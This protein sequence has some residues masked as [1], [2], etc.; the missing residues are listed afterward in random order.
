MKHAPF[1]VVVLAIV[2]ALVTVLVDDS[3]SKLTD[4][5]AAIT[6]QKDKNDV[7]RKTVNELKSE[8]DGIQQNDRTLEKAARNEL[9]MARPNELIFLFNNARKETDDRAE[10]SPE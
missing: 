5:K 6:G 10:P 3:F 9:G 4:L 2:T 7:L 8:V 1:I